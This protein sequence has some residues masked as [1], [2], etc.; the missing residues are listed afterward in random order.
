VLN[1]QEIGGGALRSYQPEI[2]EA[3]FESLGYEK[4]EIRKQFGHFFKLLNTG[5][6]LTAE[7]L[8]V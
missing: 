8:S 4:E 6:L 1:G 2:L 5:S 3:V 7:W